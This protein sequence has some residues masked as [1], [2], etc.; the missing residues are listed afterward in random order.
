MQN[1]NQ[2][3]ILHEITLMKTLSLTD[4]DPKNTCYGYGNLSH[5]GRMIFPFHNYRE[6][7]DL[8]TQRLLILNLSF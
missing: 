4:E 3:V 5:K 6:K 2:M 8:L 7:K 1:D